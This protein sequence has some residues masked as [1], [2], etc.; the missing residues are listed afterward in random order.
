[1]RIK[2]WHKFQH[3]KDRRPPWIKLHRE[4]LDQ[5][6]IMA[7]S[8]RS[9]KVLVCLWL[10]ASEDETMQGVLPPLS[11]IS[12][13]LRMS[14]KD[15]IKCFDELNDL[16]IRD[17]NAMISDCHHVDDPE[18]ET[19]TET[20]KRR[21]EERVPL[22]TANA[23]P[24]PVIQTWN[25]MASECGLPKAQ[26]TKKRM[27]ALKVRMNEAPFQDG[28]KEAIAKI[29]SSKFLTGDND[30]GWRADLDWFLKPDS[31][32][33]IIEGKYDGHGKQHEIAE[34]IKKAQD[35]CDGITF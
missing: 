17:D 14:K 4:I 15:L 33:R 18:T 1:M 3:F 10:M 20:E 35:D 12:W 9:F 32:V 19:E 31:V 8:E 23:V 11:D 7:I 13:R 34:A 27:A 25:D 6:D 26:S 29:P 22:S 5:R 24:H 28:W 30:R 2:N 21:E 16:L